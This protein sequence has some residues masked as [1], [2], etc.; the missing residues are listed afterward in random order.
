MG[1]EAKRASGEW[2]WEVDVFQ[3]Q[4]RRPCHGDATTKG[5]PGAHASCGI[6]DFPQ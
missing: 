6:F 2:E 3:M 4:R 1:D 5:N